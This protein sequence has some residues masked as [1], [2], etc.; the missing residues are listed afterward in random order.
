[1]VA[2]SMRGS[3]IQIKRSN[4]RQAEATA[5][6]ATEILRAALPKGYFATAMGECRWGRALAGQNHAEEARPRLE[7]AAGVLEQNTLVPHTYELE[8]LGA[9]VRLYEAAGDVELAV[10]L[11]VR[12]AEL[13]A[14]VAES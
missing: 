13:E 7:S 10:P 3:G 11:R 5:R 14:L 6:E 12:V 9:L 1:M 8:C 4:Y 2:N